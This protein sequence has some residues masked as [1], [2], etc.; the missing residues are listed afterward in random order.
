MHLNLCAF[1]GK[2]S[3]AISSCNAHNIAGMDFLYNRCKR[4]DT[5]AKAV[6]VEVHK[7]S[8]TK[9]AIYLRHHQTLDS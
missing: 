9:L 3:S 4:N 2:H 5:M 1:T 6:Q 8:V 7:N